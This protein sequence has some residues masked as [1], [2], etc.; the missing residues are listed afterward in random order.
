VDARI[1]NGA[2]DLTIAVAM[3]V[4]ERAKAGARDPDRLKT[5]ALEAIR[6]PPTDRP[7]IDKKPGAPSGTVWASEGGTN[8]SVCPRGIMAQSP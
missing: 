1:L 3:K 7:D 2:N 5:A 6:R 4:F 8:K